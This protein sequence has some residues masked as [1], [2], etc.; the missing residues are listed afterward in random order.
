MVVW[1]FAGGGEAEIEGLIPF[2]RR[3]FP[4]CE[5]QRKTPVRKKR[6]PKPG[7]D[8]NALGKTGKSLSRQ[9]KYQLPK[10]LLSETCDLILVLDDL[11]CQDPEERKKAFSDAIDCVNAAANT[12][13]FTAFAAPELEAW[14][15]A[16]W[17]NTFARHSDFRGFH[18]G[19]RYTLS[20]D[21]KVPL[22]NPESFSEYDP[23]QDSCRD[24]L[25]EVIIQAVELT[26]IRLKNELTGYSKATH[27]PELLIHTAGRNMSIVQRNVHFFEKVLQTGLSK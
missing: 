6:G 10:A 23:E 13:R 7:K 12:E 26:A 15:I 11:D 25:S 2:F 22:D 20:H 21:C 17:E 1:L 9:I 19:L 18:E 3:N 14:I 4:F 5:F 27:T 8:I 16:D 24:K